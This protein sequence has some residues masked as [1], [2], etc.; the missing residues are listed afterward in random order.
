LECGFDFDMD[1]PLTPPVWLVI[2]ICAVVM[3]P[4]HKVSYGSTARSPVGVRA[5]QP[6]WNCRAGTP[7]GLSAVR[8]SNSSAHRH[9][10]AEQ[11]VVAGLSLRAPITGAATVSM[12]IPASD[13]IPAVLFLSPAATRGPPWSD[14]QIDPA[15]CEQRA[16]LGRPARHLDTVSLPSESHLSRSRSNEIIAISPRSMLLARSGL[17]PKEKTT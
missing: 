2:A 8:I 9:A 3:V 5:L 7:D 6:D 14:N 1:F 13:A 15:L 17:S 4:A 12:I 16:G 11:S 10:T